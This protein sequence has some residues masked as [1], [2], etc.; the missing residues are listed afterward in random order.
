MQIGHLQYACPLARKDPKRNKKQQK[1]PNGW[2]HTEPLEEEDIQP[3]HTINQ[4]EL[5]INMEQNGTQDEKAPD[6]QMEDHIQQ[7][8]FPQLEVSGIKRTH[9]SEGSESDKEPPVNTQ[10]YQQAIIVPPT[11]SQGW[12]RVEKKKGRKV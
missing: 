8:Q 2:Q 3:E 9:G 1:K 10:E 7:Q 5:D 12:C 6:P 11:H 4:E